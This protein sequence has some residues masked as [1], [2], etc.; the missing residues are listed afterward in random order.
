MTGSPQ[1]FALPQ[2]LV[3]APEIDGR[4]TWLASLPQS[5][6]E[7]ASRWSLTV[8]DPFQPGGETAWVA[9]VRDASGEE[10][11][12]KVGWR[13]PEALHEAAGLRAWDGNGAV[14]LYAAE[15]TEDTTYLLLEACQPGTPLSDLPEEEQDLVVAEMLPRLW[16]V[17][18]PDHPFRPLQQMC[19]EWA[20]GFEARGGTAASSLDAGLVRAGIALL[21]SLPASAER[22]VLLSTDL[23]ADN[24]LAA[25]R[26]PWLMIDPKPYVGDPTYDA[27]QYVLHLESRLAADARGLVARLA[28]LFELD[29]DRLALWLFARCVQE[30]IDW[31][32]LAAVA[33]ELA[34]A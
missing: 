26:E 10:M 4:T 28:D 7:I 29:R 21:R 15:E 27:L 31:P 11:V 9:P 32:F 16:G 25:R 18:V 19:D 2:N 14:R 17:E 22:E 23:H 12:L 30:S 6:S 20:D 13:H 1:P 24:V 33:R 8:G 5:V 3:E 34:P